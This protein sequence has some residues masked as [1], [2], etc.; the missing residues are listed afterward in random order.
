VSTYKVTLLKTFST[1]V[2][3]ETDSTDEARDL[4][5]ENEPNDNIVGF[6]WEPDGETEVYVIYDEND[7]EVW[8][9]R[10]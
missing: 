7:K 1:T 10:E 9:Q 2:E 5:Y 3:V 4:A 8:R 6:D